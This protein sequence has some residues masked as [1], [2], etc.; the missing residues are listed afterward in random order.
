MFGENHSLSWHGIL[1]NPIDSSWE[2]LNSAA[3][4]VRNQQPTLPIWEAL[5]KPII[6][7]ES[8]NQLVRDA[9]KVRSIDHRAIY[10][11]YINSKGRPEETSGRDYQYASTGSG[12]CLIEDKTIL[13]GPVHNRFNL[14]QW[15]L[16]DLALAHEIV[17]ALYPE[18]PDRQ[19]YGFDF[20]RRQNFIVVEWTAR[21]VRAN[22]ELLKAAVLG[23]GLQ[24]RIYDG[25]SLKAFYE[26]CGFAKI[27][28]SQLRIDYFQ[29]LQQT[30]FMD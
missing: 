3:L 22:P 15:Y 13:L 23:F 24:A 18:T 4:E 1:V 20:T 7:S 2:D 30:V 16:R 11:D 8:I 26:H 21:Q 9:W 5:E 19:D 25:V 29:R 12:G 6:T 14:S 17:H 10:K 27:P 28:H